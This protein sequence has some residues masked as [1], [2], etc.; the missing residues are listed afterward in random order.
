MADA[1]AH[2]KSI[3]DRLVIALSLTLAVLAL[4]TASVWAES[5]TE[6]VGFEDCIGVVR[7]ED[8]Q[9][10]ICGGGDVGRNRTE[11][12]VRLQDFTGVVRLGKGTQLVSVV[13]PSE[14]SQ[15]VMTTYFVTS[16]SSDTPDTA[17][18]S[19]TSKE[20]STLK[21]KWDEWE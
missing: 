1:A 5:E 13:F 17:S 6:V 4:G 10:D 16:P 7:Y 15:E 11:R 8:G 9:R 3:V 19:K 12:V 18:A 14:T 20:S 2:R 21:T